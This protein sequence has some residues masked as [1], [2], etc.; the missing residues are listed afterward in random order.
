VTDP[1]T[2]GVPFLRQVF[3]NVGNLGAAALGQG[4]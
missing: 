2:A 3:G 4:Q 1:S